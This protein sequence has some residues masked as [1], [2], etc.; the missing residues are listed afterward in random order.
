MKNLKIREY[1]RWNLEANEASRVREIPTGLPIAETRKSARWV[2]CGNLP[3]RSKTLRYR[4]TSWSHQKLS[5]TML[6]RRL[7][8][9]WAQTLL[10]GNLLKKAEPRR[11]E[12]YMSTED[13]VSKR[14]SYS[15]SWQKLDRYR[16]HR[17][18]GP[19]KV[20]H[21]SVNHGLPWSDYCDMTPGISSLLRRLNV[22]Q[23]TISNVTD[24]L[25]KIFKATVRWYFAMQDQRD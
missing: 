12:E 24:V 23:L 11:N 7:K 8:D 4:T 9:C 19:V 15:C 3:S 6:R 10:Q 17:E 1:I 5:E 25:G 20:V 22:F 2:G 14:R 18:I 13:V 16:N 21:C